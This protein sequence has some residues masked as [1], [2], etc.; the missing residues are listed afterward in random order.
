MQAWGQ[1]T[2]TVRAVKLKIR[3]NMGQSEPKERSFKQGFKELE[4][5][6]T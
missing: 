5:V 3:V 6:R 1:K 2:L 4:G